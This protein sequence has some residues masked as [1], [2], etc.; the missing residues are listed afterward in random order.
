MN[1]FNNIFRKKHHKKLKDKNNQFWISFFRG[2]FFGA[3][4]VVGG[5]VV[6]AILVGIL[7]IF[8]DLPGVV[9]DF[10]SSVIEELNSR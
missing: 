7:G 6:I 8:A 3:G 5:T 2:I 10:V 1:I 4:S 9:G